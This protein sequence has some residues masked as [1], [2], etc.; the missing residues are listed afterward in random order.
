MNRLITLSAMLLFCGTAL[1]SQEITNAITQIKYKGEVWEISSSE[2]MDE[3]DWV[4]G[5]DDMADLLCLQIYTSTEDIGKYHYFN[6]DALNLANTPLLAIPFLSCGVG[7]EYYVMRESTDSFLLFE[8]YTSADF[9][10]QKRVV[11]LNK[12]S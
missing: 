6:D 5:N 4:H 9:V 1:F 10:G 12:I 7:Y 2:T 11:V 3:Y 8:Y